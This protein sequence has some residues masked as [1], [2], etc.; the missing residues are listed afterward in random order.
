MNKIEIIKDYNE[1]VDI[2]ES[3]IE[4]S[5]GNSF[6]LKDI[7]KK[8]Y[9][10][11]ASKYLSNARTELGT[12]RYFFN[13]ITPQC[14]HATKN[15][16][17]DRKD[18]NVR[19]EKPEDDI[20]AM[21][22]NDMFKMWLKKQS[23]GKLL[24]KLS[25]RI[26]K[27][28]SVFFKRVKDNIIQRPLNRL[29]FDPSVSSNDNDFDVPSPFLIDDYNLDVKELLSKK[30]N[31]WDSKEVDDIVDKMKDRSIKGI[32]VHEFYNA[33]EK[34]IFGNGEGYT[35]G[36]VYLAEI[37]DYYKKNV[38]GSKSYYNILFKEKLDKFP[39]KK[40]D[41]L[42]IEGRGLGLGI[43]EILF[44]IQ[45]RWNEISNDR[46]V[47]SK[48]SNKQ[49]FQTRD[50]NVGRNILTDIENGEILKVASE[51][52]RVPTE[53]RNLGAYQQEENNLMYMMRSLANAQ[54][55]ITGE[56]LPSRTPFRLGAMMKENAGK[57]FDFIREN[58]GLFLN[59]VFTE[60]V[61]EDFDKE[62]MKKHIFKV[63]DEE[64]IARLVEG[65]VNRRINDAIVKYTLVRGTRP[66]QYEIDMIK[67]QLT[68]ESLN[69]KV[70]FADIIDGYL[71]FKKDIDI[72]TTGE[73][74]NTGAEV[75]TMSNML[76]LMAQNPQITQDPNLMK[77]LKSIASKVGLNPMIL[78][79]KTTSMPPLN[80]LGK[81]P[82]TNGTP[83]I[84]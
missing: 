50:P 35:N 53:E 24:N 84:Q 60:W 64:T 74:H 3:E 48:T 72:D 43:T 70:K 2:Y 54:E 20:K 36:V 49:L 39:Y 6:N 62:A 5:D 67:E 58:M 14:G 80:E 16:D 33:F 9:L 11:L 68:S 52:T 25:D 82:M 69:G 51:I 77:M 75:E 37:R 34:S 42:T 18:I 83:P 8:I 30:D 32:V 63:Y 65:D 78:P 59:E 4:I 21:L 28:G 40:V 56:N 7:V 19:A 23:I 1:C 47:S 41:Y 76:Q 27:D 44:D 46:A 13:I 10:Y 66:A 22:Y 45:R 38:N 73:K 31:G 12:K 29:K 57:L 26:P 17:I 55:I 81:T 79:S 61:I 15:I 71:K